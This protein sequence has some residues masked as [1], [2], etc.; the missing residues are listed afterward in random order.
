MG[1]VALAQTDQGFGEMRV[2]ARRRVVARQRRAEQFRALSPIAMLT[3]DD[4]QE[5][6]RVG[7]SGVHAQRFEAQRMRIL[8]RAAP[9]SCL[10][11]MH[12][13]RSGGFGRHAETLA[14][15]CRKYNKIRRARACCLEYIRAS[16]DAIA[17]T[18]R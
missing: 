3:R 8:E 4:A 9:H 14:P 2:I 12:Q 13:L 16:V 10:C 15:A 1:A 17:Q 6:K 5:E 18:S 11:V 7:A